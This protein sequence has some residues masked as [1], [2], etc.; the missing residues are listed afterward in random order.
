MAEVE[1]K[2]GERG[3]YDITDIGQKRVKEG[4]MGWNWGE[5]EVK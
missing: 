4:E 2:L 3:W 1:V 5:I